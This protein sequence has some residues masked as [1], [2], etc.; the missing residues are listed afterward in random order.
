MWLCA[1]WAHAHEDAHDAMAPGSPGVK[2]GSAVALVAV[3]SGNAVP[4]AALPGVLDTG[5]APLDQAEHPLE[6][7]TL[8]M[9]G[10]FNPQ[11]LTVAAFGW[12]GSERVHTEA[13][14]IQWAG[15]AHRARLGRQT[16]D[17]GAV[18]NGAG[19][20][21]LYTQA[22]LAVRATTG[23]TWDDDGLQWRWSPDEAGP[24]QALDMGVWRMGTFP[25]GPDRPAAW[26]LH[27]QWQWGTLALDAHLS[28]V[29]VRGRGRV[30]AATGASHTHDTPDCTRTLVQ[31][32]CFDG[33]ATLVGASARW[34][35][36]NS[37][38]ALQGAW[39]LRD[40][41]GDLYTASGD[42]DYRGRTQGG[43]LDLQW[44]I[45]PA[46]RTGLR[47]ERLSPRHTLSGPSAT[48]VATQTGLATAASSSRSTAMLAWQAHPTLQLLA[49][50]GTEH[51]GNEGTQRH[52]AI[53]MIWRAS[54]A[55]P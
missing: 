7:A 51:R 8:Q 12:H 35:P 10:R 37:A 41:R 15:D 33:R 2:L 18:T 9:G 50:A 44:Q 38:L 43:W 4:A 13:A 1:A 30:L 47:V 24:L 14:W 40:E 49:E 52:A 19:H 39:L 6:H 26:H 23:G 21:D 16:V 25:A 22:P 42:T 31:L 20:F 54:H 3:K 34:A 32:A 45:Q 48:S 55:L 5:L 29:Q 17:R 36:A 27:P 53:R 28:R 11:W 46:W